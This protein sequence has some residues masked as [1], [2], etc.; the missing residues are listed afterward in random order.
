[1]ASGNAR[2]AFK[3]ITPRV[4]LS[5]DGRQ[6]SSTRPA[7]IKPADPDRNPDDRGKSYP[8]D[9]LAWILFWGCGCG[10]TPRIG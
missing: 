1:M 2:A 5:N 10:P 4:V 8:S 7:K 3:S 6:A 9:I